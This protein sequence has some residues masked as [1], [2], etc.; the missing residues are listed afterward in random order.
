MRIYPYQNG[1]W[2]V[3]SEDGKQTVAHGYLEIQSLPDH[4]AGL[5]RSVPVMFVIDWSAAAGVGVPVEQW[6]QPSDVEDAG[7][8]DFDERA[9]VA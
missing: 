4:P 7:E 8:D 5:V 9:R 2:H 1:K 3:L 6:Q